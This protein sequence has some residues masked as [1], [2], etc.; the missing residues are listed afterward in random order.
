ML[1][2][3]HANCCDFVYFCKIV[4]EEADEVTNRYTYVVMCSQIIVLEENDNDGFVR[5]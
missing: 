5:K 3:I 2:S 1:F 4:K